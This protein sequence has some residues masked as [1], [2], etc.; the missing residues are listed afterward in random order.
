M[1]KNYQ[2]KLFLGY[3]LFFFLIVGTGIFFTIGV[4]D[5]A[6][7]EISTL[8]VM[9]VTLHIGEMVA[10]GDLQYE[11]TEIWEKEGK[12]K[13][14]TKNIKEFMILSVETALIKMEMADKDTVNRL[15]QEELNKFLTYGIQAKFSATKVEIDLEP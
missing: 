5:K 2:N 4:K 3:L 10:V 11:L 1:N 7:A 13:L 6:K 12:E 8:L 14:V 15:I 9:P